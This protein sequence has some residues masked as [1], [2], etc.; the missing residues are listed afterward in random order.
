MYDMESFTLDFG[1][2]KETKTFEANVLR[3]PMNY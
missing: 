1:R 3:M 2:F